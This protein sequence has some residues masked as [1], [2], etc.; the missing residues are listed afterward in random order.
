MKSCG[1][2]I[3]PVNPNQYTKEMMLKV[4][5]T[6]KT[7]SK[8][9]NKNPAMRSATD[10]QGKKSFPPISILESFCNIAGTT[11]FLRKQ[12]LSPTNFELEGDAGEDCNK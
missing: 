9:L 3:S 2:G 11:Y 5:E 10:A 6:V 7:I 4:N 8:S 1:S 12:K